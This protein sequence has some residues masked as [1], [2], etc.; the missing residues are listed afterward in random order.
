MKTL[1]K[2]IIL[3]ALNIH[4]SYSQYCLEDRHTTNI[5]DAWLSCQK[6]VNPNNVSGNSHWILYNF[7]SVRSLYETTIWNINHPDYINNGVKRIRIDYSMDKIN[8]TFWGEVNIAKAEARSDYLG[9]LG[10]DFNGLSARHVLITVMETYGDM[11]CAG[12]SEIKIYTEDPNCPNQLFFDANDNMFG[13]ENYQA[14]GIILNNTLDNNADITL[15]AEECIQFL[16][17]FSLEVGSE[18]HAFIADCI[19]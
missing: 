1:L 17:G 8:W 9:E 2:V 14:I 10:P 11:I 6:T 7:D 15:T 12:F 16:E 3:I 13:I 4:V 5:T 18:L 19:D